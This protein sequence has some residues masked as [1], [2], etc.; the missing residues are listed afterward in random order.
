VV[1]SRVRNTTFAGIALDRGLLETRRELHGRDHLQCQRAG[2]RVEHRVGLDLSLPAP[3]PEQF[4]NELGVLL[5]VR[6]ADMIRLG[7]ELLEL[8]GVVVDLEKRI[9]LLIDLEGLGS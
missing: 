2:R 3:V 4:Q 8:W 9:E 5:V 1:R 6:R 7:R